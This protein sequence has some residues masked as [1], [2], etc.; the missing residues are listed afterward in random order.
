[1]KGEIPIGATFTRSFTVDQARVI[2]FMGPEISVYATPAMIHDIEVTCRDWLL[3]QLGEGEDSVGARVE[4]VHERPTPLGMAV[5]HSVRVGALAGRRVSFEITVRDAVEQVA[6]AR[7]ER[8]VV[9]KAR[10]AVAV[11][12]KGE[13]Q[14]QP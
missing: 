2:D 14:G 8:V 9:D 3:S 4:I 11:R 7:H 12:R 10:L 5:T 1:M 6:Q 13:R